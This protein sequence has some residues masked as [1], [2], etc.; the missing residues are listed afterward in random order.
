MASILVFMTTATRREAQE[1]VQTLL[2][3]RLIACANIYG[4]VESHF[5]WQNKIEK[6][7]EFLVLMKSNH[8]LFTK[9]SKKIK[10]MHSYD[11]PEIL[12]VPILEG[13]PTYLEWLN[14]SLVATGEP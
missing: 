4:P 13:F 9:L 11:V 14:T 8:N 5:R 10:K 6:A 1:I 7:S 2:D 12:A 3:K